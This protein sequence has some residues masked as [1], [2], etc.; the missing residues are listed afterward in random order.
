MKYDEPTLI[1]RP[2]EARNSV[3][4]KPLSGW[5]AFLLIGVM[6]FAFLI[7][8][9]VPA[10][11][12][13]HDPLFWCLVVTIVFFVWLVLALHYEPNRG[14]RIRFIRVFCLIEVLVFAVGAVSAIV[15]AGHA[16]HRIW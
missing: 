11:P 3:N 8:N 10:P 13:Y 2:R 6:V 4:P 14:D 16:G 1:A 7:T 12:R 15:R 5:I 9:A